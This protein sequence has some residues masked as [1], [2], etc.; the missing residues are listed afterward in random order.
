MSR[1]SS[2]LGLPLY[3]DECTTK[4]AR[5]SIARVMIELDITKEIPLM[6]K[7]EDPNGRMFDQK[8]I[9]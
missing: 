8:V 9:H 1:I 6:I 3:A 5:I 2:C 4:V 7:V